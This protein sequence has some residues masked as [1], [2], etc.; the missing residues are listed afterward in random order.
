MIM[1]AGGRRLARLLFVKIPLALFVLSVLWVLVLRWVP[2]RYTP[3]MLVRWIEFRDEEGFRSE[4]QWRPLEDV[5]V[6][7]RKAVVASEDN[8]FFEH[9]GFDL[10]QIRIALESH[11]K[12]GKRL[13]GAST[14]S[15]QT[16]KN[17]F[18]LPGRSVVRKAAEA[19]F[20][21]LIEVL[22]GKRRILE[23]YL[24]VIET[25]KGL[26]GVEAAAQRYFGTSAAKLSRRQASLVSVC[27]PNP[28]KMSPLRPSDYVKRRAAVISSRIGTLEYPRWVEER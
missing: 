15:Q 24:N 5:S 21:V 8:L 20:T 25:G 11:F 6:W 23:V 22:W 3:L 12:Q 13:R 19:Y 7:M 14:I 4:A 28:L 27:L 2:V 1:A 26:Y 10:K 9:K 16:A 18:L 17:V